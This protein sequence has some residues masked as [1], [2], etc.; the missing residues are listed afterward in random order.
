MNNVVLRVPQDDLYRKV[1][2]EHG[3]NAADRCS[4]NHSETNSGSRR[5]PARSQINKGI[6]L[7]VCRS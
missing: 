7:P 1:E 2:S 3:G 4:E 5:A 6:A